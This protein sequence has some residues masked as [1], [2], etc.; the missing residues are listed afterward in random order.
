LAHA[1]FARA[2]GRQSAWYANVTVFCRHDVH[3]R[4][5][6]TGAYLLQ[7]VLF[8]FGVRV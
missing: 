6:S 8:V 1:S 7:R 4:G 3:L 2:H 5:A